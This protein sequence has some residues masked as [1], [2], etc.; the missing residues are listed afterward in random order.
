MEPILLSVAGSLKVAVLHDADADSLLDEQAGKLYFFGRYQS[1]GAEHGYAS[2]WD[3]AHD[4]QQNGWTAQPV[5]VEERPRLALSVKPPHG[6]GRGKGLRDPVGLAAL[7]PAEAARIWPRSTPAERRQ[8]ALILLEYEVR[9][10]SSWLQGQVWR[11][12]VSDPRQDSVV[13]S[14]GRF[15]GDPRQCLAAGLETARQIIADR[16]ERRFFPENGPFL[17]LDGRAILASPEA[18]GTGL[19]ALIAPNRE[20]LTMLCGLAQ[21][22]WQAGKGPSLQPELLLAEGVA[23][24]AGPLDLAD[25]DF[26]LKQPGAALQAL[27]LQGPARFFSRERRCCFALSEPA[28]IRTLACQPGGLPGAGALV[29]ALEGEEDFCQAE[30]PFA[31]LQE[32]LHA[33]NREQE[34]R[35]TRL[36]AMLA[37]EAE[38]G[39]T[40][41][42]SRRETL[43][44]GSREEPGMKPGM[45][46]GLASGPSAL[47]KPLPGQ[48]AGSSASLPELAGAGAPGEPHVLAYADAQHASQH[49]SQGAFQSAARGKL[50]GGLPGF[51]LAGWIGADGASQTSEDAAAQAWSAAGGEA[52]KAGE[53]GACAPGFPDS[54]TGLADASE[55]G[56]SRGQAGHGREDQGEGACDGP[57]LLEPGDGPGVLDDAE[58]DPE[59]EGDERG[60]SEGPSFG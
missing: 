16:Q 58:A 13:A 51:P 4:L 38:D 35:R 24:I 17:D 26:V 60:E 1:L 47:R 39:R 50:P 55:E 10:A 11:F 19:R 28:G 46:P 40:P 3:A 30:F 44:E 12:E 37:M 54:S 53:V 57:D 6:A 20:E 9:D 49:A 5:Y 32:A 33:L 31:L 45:E 43:G 14:C 48:P 36:A 34:R 22:I 18:Q 41:S 42:E 8:R 56:L 23:G 7:S 52:G 27:S 21:G 29:L 59:P 25:A 15:Y 2:L